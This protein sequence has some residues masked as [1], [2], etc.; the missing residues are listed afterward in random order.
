MSV[1]SKLRVWFGADTADAEKGFKKVKDEGNALTK[2]FDKLKGTIAAAFSVAAISAFAKEAY[3]LAEIQWKAEKR[4]EAG[5]KATGDAVGYSA[6]QLKKYASELQEVTL[7]GDEV[8]ISAMARLV[9]YTN[10]TGDVFKRTIALAQD[11]ATVME[12]DLNSAVV[13]LGKALNTPGKGL[14]ELR[15]AGIAFTTQQIADIQRLVAKGD[16]YAAQMLILEEAYKHVGGAAR[17]I[18]GDTETA[19]AGVQQLANTWGDLLE[20][21]ANSEATQSLLKIFVALLKTELEYYDGEK[22][23]K[24]MADRV[25]ESMERF[26]KQHDNYVEYQGE[27]ITREKY[28][29]ILAEEEARQAEAARKAELQRIQDI[30]NADESSIKAINDKITKIGELINLTSIYDSA[31]LVAY[32]NEVTRLQAVKSEYESLAATMARVS[33]FRADGSTSVSATPIT[34]TVNDRNMSDLAQM[35]QA[36]IQKNFDEAKP[37]TVPLE[38]EMDTQ[39]V[40]DTGQAMQTIFA[41]IGQALGDAISGNF[42]AEQLLAPIAD[43]AMQLGQLL[44]AVGTAILAF[45][46]SLK[47]LNPF[48]AIGAGVALVAIATAFRNFASNAASGAVATSTA[49][50]GSSYST[51]LNDYKDTKMEVSGTLKANGNELVAVINNVEK[52]NKYTK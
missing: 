46:Q 21:I 12:T 26:M 3:R 49:G 1:I 8:T 13:K 16:R 41:G 34:A 4:L 32:Q 52:H 10:V 28:A 44:I 15:E 48:V 19:Y 5:L 43:I 33:Q 30:L 31:T 14:D 29:I 37:V 45:Q 25:N 20:M 47:S 7:F 38:M 51:Q 11:L 6:K 24:D 39:Q 23:L 18:A 35:S 9:P 40:Y 2:G 36:E 50:G 17:E 42:Q 27:W 22:A